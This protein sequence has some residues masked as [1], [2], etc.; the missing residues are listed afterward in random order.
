MSEFQV[1]F[2]KN[3]KFHS[4]S[5]KNGEKRANKAP[6][7]QKQ[8][9]APNV[10]EEEAYQ[11]AL[12]DIIK[13]DF[14]PDLLEM[15]ENEK[16]E[17]NLRES[18]IYHDPVIEN[19]SE[20]HLKNENPSKQSDITHSMSLDQFQALYTSEDNASFIDILNQQNQRQRDAYDWAWNNNKIDSERVKEEGRRLMMKAA[21]PRPVGWIDDRPSQPEAWPF[22]PMNK[23][24][25]HPE[26]DYT[27]PKLLP[28]DE[29]K[30]ITYHATRMPSAY[31]E[32]ALS[33]SLSTIEN[34]SLNEKDDEPKVAGWS[35]VDDAPTPSPE[36]LGKPPMTWGEIVSTP[37]R[38]PET[39]KRA[40]KMQ[41]IPEREAL[42]HRIT[43]QLKKKNR[44]KTPATYLKEIPK[45]SSSPDLR[46]A[47]LSPGGRLLLAASGRH[48]NSL[49]SDLKTPRMTSHLKNV[50][51]MDVT[52]RKG[53]Q[54]SYN[55]STEQDKTVIISRNLR[56]KIDVLV[57]FPLKGLDLSQRVA[58]NKYN[59]GS[60]HDSQIYDLYA[61]NNHFGG[62]GGG[63]YT[64]YVASEDGYFYHFDE[65]I[66]PDSLVVR[67]HESQIVTPAAYLLFYRR[68]TD[69][70]LGEPTM[71][72]IA[73]Y[74]SKIPTK[75][76]DST[77]IASS[78]NKVSDLTMSDEKFILDP[79][80]T[81]IPNMPSG[82]THIDLS[83]RTPDDSINS[84]SHDS[85]ES[86]KITFSDGFDY[87]DK[88]ECLNSEASI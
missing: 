63:H 23:L 58:E 32:R 35:F 50:S 20:P 39:P 5:Q 9:Y 3:N 28:P 25:F 84:N 37:I 72:K 66:S 34:S 27:K 80:T 6:S 75:S 24:M 64:A 55:D 82:M 29:E 65:L 33:P 48:D 21:D 12:S 52:P 57:D 73:E 44:A 19:T 40:F 7:I 67:I 14:F 53:H 10:L 69:K 16:I 41:N 71:T 61:V 36:T 31:L 79:R 47:M 74:M 77:N 43:E 86:E 88:G 54:N 49:R 60:P 17:K 46:K 62:L 15:E 4:F 30:S 83:I 56:D 45:F 22:D 42:H 87:N 70:V 18:T 26:T 8:R 11:Q 78:L 85:I 51:T 13:R 68:R 76:Y 38:L 1:D 59:S 2:I 81:S